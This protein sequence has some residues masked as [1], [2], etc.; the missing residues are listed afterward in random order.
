MSEIHYPEDVKRL[1]TDLKSTVMSIE[2]YL[3]NAYPEGY[4][5]YK[6][7]LDRDRKQTRNKD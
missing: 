6:K 4:G 3:K 2:W 7:D 5:H 1:I